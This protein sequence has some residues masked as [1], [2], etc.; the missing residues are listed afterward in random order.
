MPGAAS[1]LY[2]ANATK[3]ILFMN[4]KNPFDFPGV[5]ATYRHG[6]TSQEA[7]GEND[8]YDF[9]FRAANK[10]SDKFAAKIT[11]SYQQGEDWHA[12]DYR[13]INH[14]DGRFVGIE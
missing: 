10:F 5:S 14:L 8:Y 9:A 12:T 11:V 2:G 7:A 1:A 4:S 6:I 3:G 13:D